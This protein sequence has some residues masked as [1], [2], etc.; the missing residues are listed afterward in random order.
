MAYC[1]HTDVTRFTGVAYSSTTSPTQSDVTSFVNEVSSEIKMLLDSYGIVGTTGTDIANVLKKYS[2][3]GATCLTL[4]RTAANPDERARAQDFCDKY[5]AWL[6]KLESDAAYRNV[7]SG[8]AYSVQNY[9]G[10]Q[11]TD[12]TTLEADVSYMDEDFAV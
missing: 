9:T 5:S 12:G 6:A 4:Q 8:L 10:N 2:S 3:I 11:V 1:A 7:L